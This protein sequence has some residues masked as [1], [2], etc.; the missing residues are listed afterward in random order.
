MEN[1]K[2]VRRGIFIVSF[3]VSADVY[4]I[5]TG[6]SVHNKRIERLWRDVFGGVI[7]LYYRL[8]YYLEEQHLLN[9][10]NEHHL[11]ALHYVYIPHI[12]QALADF[13]DDLYSKS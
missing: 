1:P 10:N 11:Y 4:S 6:P 2:I 3:I 5:I 8:F 9:P 7:K 12:N 13:R